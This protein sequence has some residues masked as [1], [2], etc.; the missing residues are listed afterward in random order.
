MKVGGRWTYIYL[1]DG[2]DAL[3][4]DAREFVHGEEEVPNRRAEDEAYTNDDRQ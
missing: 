2:Y 1:H 3:C 4:L